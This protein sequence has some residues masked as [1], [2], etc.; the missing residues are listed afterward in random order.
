M[1]RFATIVGVM[2]SAQLLA[3]DVCGAVNSSLGV[4][5]V[6][7]GNR[8]SF[9]LTYQYRTYISNHPPLFNEPGVRSTERY[10]RID[11]SGNIR[12]ASRWQ[13]KALIPIVYNEQFK[14]GTRE[15][16]QGIGDP[17]LTV[18]Y[19]VVNWQD[20]AATKNIRWSIGAGGKM[21]VGQYTDPNNQ[22]LLLYPGTGT[23][24]GVLQSSLYLRSN[25]WGLIQENSLVLRGTNK[26]HYTPG[27]LFNYAP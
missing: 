12:L 19:Y 21:P 1:K 8:H 14:Q 16:R 11:L 17:T 18:Q 5:T 27:S 2:V 26:Y 15:F 24:D 6:A 23:W 22:V 3:C 25:N 20:S 7:A 13:L 4:G 10:Q 9:G